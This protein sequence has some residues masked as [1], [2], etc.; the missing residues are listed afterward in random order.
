EKPVGG[1]A[2]AAWRNADRLFVGSAGKLHC[3]EPVQSATADPARS[4]DSA[5]A[6]VHVVAGSPNGARVVFSDGEQQLAVLDPKTGKVTGTAVFASRPVAAALTANGRVLAVVTRDGA[7]RV[8]HLSAGGVLEPL[9]TKRVSRSDRAAA[10]F[11]PDGR[12]LA[13]SSAGRV[14]L[15]DAVTGRPMQS[16]ERRFGEGDVSCLS[17]SPDG[18]QVA[19][20]SAGPEGVVRVSEVA[21]GAEQATFLGHTGDVNAVAF[22]PNGRSL[23]SGGADQAVLLWSAPA[24]GPGPKIGTPAE[25]WGS[26][27]ALEADAGYRNMGALLSQPGRAVTVIRDGFR[28]MADEQTKIRRWVSELDHDEFRVR[29]AARRSLLQA[30]LRAAGALNDPGRKKMGAEGETRVRLILEAMESQGLRVPESGLFGEP[31]RSV[32]AVRVLETI[33]GKDAR[34]VLEE[35]AKGSAESRLTKEAKSALETFPADSK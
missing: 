23:A 31:L 12:L 5:G 17:F 28:G 2:F 14:M 4:W 11:S 25:A 29:E 22:S 13:V 24:A 6:G 8:Y 21:T 10:Q 16:L 33:G 20:G 19:I 3:I 15:L 32:R 35:A 27:D 34:A 7:A 26:L 9:W 1:P 18:E 30:G